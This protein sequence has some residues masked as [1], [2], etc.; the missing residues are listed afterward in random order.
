VKSAIFGEIASQFLMSHLARITMVLA[1]VQDIKEDS[2]VLL[3][4]LSNGRQCL[5]RS[6]ILRVTMEL[7]AVKD[8]KEDTRDLIPVQMSPALKMMIAVED[9]KENQRNLIPLLI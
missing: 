9:M 4:L 1:A 3:L 8:P 2:K 5:L 6:N 7:E